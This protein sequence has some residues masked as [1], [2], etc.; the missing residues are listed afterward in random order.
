MM[1]VVLGTIK[2]YWEW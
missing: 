2:V 1:K